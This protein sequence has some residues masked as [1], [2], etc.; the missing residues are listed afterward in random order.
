[1]LI[2]HYLHFATVQ[3]SIHSLFNLSRYVCSNVPIR[4]N[5]LTYFM[6]MK[7]MNSQNKLK[8]S[9]RYFKSIF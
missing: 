3:R 5:L 4:S 8:I 6:G 2:P 7:D 1:M 9:D